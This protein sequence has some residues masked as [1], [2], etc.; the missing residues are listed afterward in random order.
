[1]IED[2]QEYLDFKDQLEQLVSKDHEVT[3]DWLG[4]KAYL[5]AQDLVDLMECQ[6]QRVQ[7][8]LLA[9][10]DHKATLVRDD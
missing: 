10:K 3:Q 9:L 2:R 5:A 7:Q 8:D 4:H 6:D 1:V